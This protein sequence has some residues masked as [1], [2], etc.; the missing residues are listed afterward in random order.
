MVLIWAYCFLEYVVFWLVRLS[1][2][3]CG[4]SGPELPILT[5][6][7][8]LTDMHITDQCLG[9]MLRYRQMQQQSEEESSP[10]SG[11]QKCKN[12]SV[13]QNSPWCF[14]SKQMSKK[15]RLCPVIDC[16][17]WCFSLILRLPFYLHSTSGNI[18]N[19]VALKGKYFNYNF[20][21]A[22]E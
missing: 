15:Q 8:R 13:S 4:F 2:E 3:R 18:G 20:L 10:T 21:I 14:I 1:Q 17:C 12:I 9:V 6:R 22:V 16:T 11:V 19:K 7:R 5:V